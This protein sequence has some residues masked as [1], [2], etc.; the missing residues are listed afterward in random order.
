MGRI[1][2]RWS[3]PVE[4]IIKTVTLSKE[5]DGWY[6]SLCCAEVPPQALPETG[7]E[8]G[9]D[10]GRKVFLVTANGGVR[11][12]P[13]HYRKAEKHLTKAQKRVAGRP[14]GS[15]RR[16]KAVGQCAKQHQHVRRQRRDFPHQTALALVRQDEVIDVE[17][18]QPANLSRRPA[19]KQDENGT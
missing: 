16:Q 2:V 3:R 17:A 1:A 10:V 8:T 11:E 18:I 5:A 19:P 9:I 14:K 7:Q 15:K 12:N 13:R 4:G 6:V